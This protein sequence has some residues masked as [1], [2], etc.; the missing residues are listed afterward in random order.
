MGTYVFGPSSK[1]WFA[2][3]DVSSYTNRIDTELSVEELDDTT[4]GDAT[5]S[6]KSG[7]RVAKMM[8]G[9]FTN[10]AEPDA[11]FFA[12]L[13]GAGTAPV[14]F[15]PEDGSEGNIAFSM[16][17]LLASHKPLMA[18]VGEL[19]GFE[20]SNTATSPMVRGTVL[21]DGTTSRTSSSS[22][23]GYQL[24]AVSSSQSVYG[25]LHVHTSNATGTLDVIVQ[26]DNGAGFASPTTQLTFT[27]VTDV[28][29]E[30]QSAAGAITDDYWRVNWTI[31]GGATASF[32]VVV[33]IL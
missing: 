14:S 24:G 6:T 23:T 25:A 16:S 11:S 31:A 27:Q 21:E 18:S 19:S 3:Q 7:L 28:T 9:G 30:W 10:Y 22:G 8:F 12:D 4:L 17:A 15:A 1:A 32:V 20:I 13:G 5:R 29:S 26:S 2:E 33:G